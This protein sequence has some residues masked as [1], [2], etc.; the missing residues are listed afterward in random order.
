M[1]DK[2]ET[3]IEQIVDFIVNKP[4]EEV[5]LDDYTILNNE[6]KDIRF[7][8][9]QAGQNKRMAEL[10]AMVSDPAYVHGVAGTN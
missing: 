9:S 6:L 3:K 10:M 4:I 8:E 1:K 7:R 5:T 2:I